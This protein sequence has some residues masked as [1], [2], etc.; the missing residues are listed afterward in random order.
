MEIPRI[1]QSVSICFNFILLFS[2][3]GFAGSSNRIAGQP[4]MYA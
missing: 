3:F 1:A 2:P 4:V